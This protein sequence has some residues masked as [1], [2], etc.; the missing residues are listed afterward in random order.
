MTNQD[1]DLEF[2]TIWNGGEGL[3]PPRD[4]R[5]SETWSPP[6]RL[7]N[8]SGKFKG[9]SKLKGEPSETI[10]DVINED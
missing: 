7:Y 8:R 6:R 3:I 4:T 5:E 10:I 2:D 1:R 9:K